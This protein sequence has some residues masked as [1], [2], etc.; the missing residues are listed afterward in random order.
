MY[1]MIFH[2][3][4]CHSS[5]IS[6]IGRIQP[7]YCLWCPHLSYEHVSNHWLLLRVG[8]HGYE[9]SLHGSSQQVKLEKKVDFTKYFFNLTLS[10]RL[11]T[12]V[13]LPTEFVHL[14]IS[15][16]IHTCESIKDK[17]IQ[18]RLVRLLCVFL[19]SLIRNKIINVQELFIEVQVRK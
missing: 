15:N 5:S 14:Y 3:F 18:N 9:S 10:S 17:Y 12:T 4:R 6:W 7:R 1:Y 13:E 2:F 8:K 19:Q 11:T 16:C